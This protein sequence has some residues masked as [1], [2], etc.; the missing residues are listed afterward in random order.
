MSKPDTT[1]AK[2]YRI[3][4]VDDDPLICKR[5]CHILNDSGMKAVAFKSGSQLLN[6]LRDNPP[7]DLILLDI[8]MPEMDGFDTLK[9]LRKREEKG[10]EIPVIFLTANEDASV[11]EKSLTSGAMDFIKKPFIANILI[12]RV[13]H[14]V[15]LVRLQRNL[16]DEVE[17]KTREK[18]QLFLHV[19]ETKN[20]LIFNFSHDI[21]TPL[22]AI[23]GYS[24]LA[25]KHLNDTTVAQDYLQKVSTAG[26]L[27]TALTNNLLEL[28]ELDANVVHSKMG[29]N[30]LA[31]V[32]SE[33]VDMLRPEFNAKSI[34]ITVNH[35]DV[36][37]K[38]IMDAPRFQ[39]ALSHILSNAAKFTPNNGKVMV[40]ILQKGATK[41]G[42][43]RF[44]V[45]VTDTGIGMSSEFLERAFNAFER[46]ETS[47]R[48]GKTGTGI[49]LTITKRIMDILGG[50]VTV[51]S[52]KGKGSTFTLSLPLKLFDGVLDTQPT[53]QPLS[54]ICI[55]KKRIL[56][57]EDI[58][59]NR[60]LAETV[61]TESGFE[62]ESVTDGCDAVEAVANK[63]QGYYAAVLMDIQMP[64]MNGYEATRAI[65]ALDRK[66]AASLPIIALSANARMQDKAMSFESGMNEHV[67]KPFDVQ[68]LIGILN[69]Y[70][71]EE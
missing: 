61:L 29:K 28:S 55:G 18:E 19:N 49:G 36:Q 54:T 31:V 9:E 40:S 32:V 62:V 60:M 41:S 70:M 53:V 20:T 34:A 39:R 35:E 12:L 15:E 69:K 26:K 52:E 16:A 71:I 5:A 22:N 68:E 58:E 7:P 6:Y 33:T 64:V 65:R 46:E 24:E 11:E 50:S 10:K 45:A 44:D 42:Y 4:V 3:I 56:L 37:T 30:D 25:R 59:I 67:A 21:L 66:D 1:V 13:K 43:V 48:S 23:L 27:L 51:T 63:P 2:E 14:A 47:T 38:V 8:S 57:V 17:K